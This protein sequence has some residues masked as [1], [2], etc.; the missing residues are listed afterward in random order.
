MRKT[1]AKLRRRFSWL[2][3]LTIAA[4]STPGTAGISLGLFSDGVA[5]VEYF[6]GGN[7]PADVTFSRTNNNAWDFNSSGNITQVNANIPRFDYGF[8]G[9]TTL[10]GL[11][12]EGTAQNE[13]ISSRDL[14]NAAWT[15]SSAT[16]ALSQAG[17]DGATNS[18]SSITATG[19]DATVFQSFTQSAATWTF[20]AYVKR[21]SGTGVIDMTQD[22]GVTWT[23]I[24]PTSAWVK[25]AVPTQ[26]TANPV[27]G[28]RVVNS[29]DEIAVD[30]VQF[31]NSGVVSS[32]I[33]TTSTALT[34]NTESAIVS[35]VPWYNSNAGTFVVRSAISIPA[36]VNGIFSI[37]DGVGNNFI[38]CRAGQG[39]CRISSG[40]ATQWQP[41]FS[42]FSQ[43]TFNTIGI[44]Y[45]AAAS[46]FTFNG[47]FLQT[48]GAITLPSSITTLNL[49]ALNGNGFPLEGWGEYLKYWNY[50]IASNQMQNEATIH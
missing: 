48:S 7:L 37:N 30:A 8:P 44:S 46:A 26:T 5:H 23:A 19:P 34:R 50:K 3:A 39:F 47:G 1:M 4:I 29:G 15:A 18:A 13:I 20:G 12:I 49:F 16:V 14:T 33:I 40:G 43:N 22:D 31:Q 17:I 42:V 11:L 32:A 9:S 36:S 6:N 38:D 2:V 24:S 27:V 41:S 25:Y 21:I 45:S 28:F 10:Q 35:S